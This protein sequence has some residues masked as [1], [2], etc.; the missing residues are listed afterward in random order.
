[1]TNTDF[2]FLPLTTPSEGHNLNLA[3]SGGLDGRTYTD[4]SCLMG[5]P[6]WED[7]QGRMC[8]SEF[9]QCF[10]CKMKLL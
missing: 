4:H 1:M 7:N 2:Y 6:W 10:G 9:V 3:H 5:N 8:F